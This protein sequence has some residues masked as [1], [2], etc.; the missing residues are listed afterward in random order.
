LQ[1][2]IGM[3]N[4][5]T[6]S[7]NIVSSGD[8]SHTLFSSHF[9]EY[10]HSSFGAV[11]ESRHIFIDAGLKFATRDKT[12]VNVFEVGFG[13]GLNTLLTFQYARQH[14]IIVNYFAVEAFPV[15]K[16]VAAGLNY[17]EL[18]KVE[19]E[20]FIAMHHATGQL[21]A[22]APFFYL[23]LMTTTLQDVQLEDDYFDVVYFDAF[24]PDVQPEMWAV[25]CFEKIYAAM[26]RGG[27]LT[28]YSCKGT[29]KRALI[30]AGFTIEKLPGPPGKREFLRAVKETV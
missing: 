14:D 24:S 22:I 25:S 29:V 20:T 8:G 9:G 13:T 27:V 21:S 1:I 18:L 3:E 23:A 12:T 26:K 2:V 28:T 10:Y 15:G 6:F 4:K 30:K 19:Q 5:K 17:P 16:K 7:G 11:Q